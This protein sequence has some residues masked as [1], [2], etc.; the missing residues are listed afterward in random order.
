MAED[1]RQ[2]IRKTL[3]KIRTRVFV[4]AA[5]QEHYEALSIQCQL[6]AQQLAQEKEQEKLLEHQYLDEHAAAWPMCHDG[7]TDDEQ[8][9]ILKKD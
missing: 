6:F 7:M 1:I 2:T 8:R 5:L 4:N 3:T 9:R